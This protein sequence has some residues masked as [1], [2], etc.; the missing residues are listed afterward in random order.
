YTQCAIFSR[1]PEGLRSFGVVG[2]CSHVRRGR[3][4]GSCPGL[5]TCA[6]AQSGAHAPKKEEM[7]MQSSMHGPNLVRRRHVNPSRP[8]RTTGTGTPGAQGISLASA[9]PALATTYSITDVGNLGYP[10]ARPAAINES[11]QVAGTSYLAKRVEFN[12]GC[13]P[14]H[15]PCFVHPEHPFLWS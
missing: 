10:T 4:A 3:E 5:M 14:K 11:G 8:A 9:A 15:R 1:S 7:R 6:P 13:P 12:I 2:S